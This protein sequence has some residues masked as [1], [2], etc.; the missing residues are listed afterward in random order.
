MTT[1]A[2]LQ[3]IAT[4]LDTYRTQFA[5]LGNALSAL[6]FVSDQLIAQLD[7]DREALETHL[8][9]ALAVEAAADTETETAAPAHSIIE[10]TT[11]AD[12]AQTSAELPEELADEPV[13]EEAEHT[14][15][16]AVIAPSEDDLRSIDETSPAEDAAQPSPA[17]AVASEIEI[18]AS[19][20]EAAVPAADTEA[21]ATE[22]A[23]VVTGATETTPTETTST[24]T[25]AT[26]ASTDAAIDATTAPATVAS[27]ENVIS[28]ADRRKSK[29]ANSPTRRRTKA[30]VASIL[31]LAG[32]TFGLHELLQSDLG[33]RMLELGVCDGDML[34][35]TRDCSLLAWLT[36]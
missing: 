8:Q 4:S 7:H 24:E 13:A 19:A 14:A 11:P 21:T 20:A 29:P 34:S 35:A 33:Q 30:F 6:R 15:E 12:E 5:A 31:V 27:D 17:T 2:Q 3:S 1:S 25:G 36:I 23:T 10:Q 22:T 16:T 26:A 28:L 32:S 18:D 9:A